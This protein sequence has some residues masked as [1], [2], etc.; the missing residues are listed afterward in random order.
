[1]VINYEQIKARRKELGWS[2]A[3]LARLTK[4]SKLTILKIESGKGNPTLK[5][6]CKIYEVLENGKSR[7]K[8]QV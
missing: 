7:Q 5:T 1:M 3:V 2:Q 4:L 8:K 6:Y